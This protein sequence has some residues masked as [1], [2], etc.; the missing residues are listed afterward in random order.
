MNA[1][2]I[3]TAHLSTFLI[4]IILISSTIFSTAFIECI[5]E[6][7]LFPSCIPCTELQW[8]I[9]IVSLL[10]GAVLGSVMFRNTKPV[11]QLRIADEFIILG[12]IGLLSSFSYPLIVGSRFCMGLGLGLVSTSVLMYFKQT[13]HNKFYL[14]IIS[15][16]YLIGQL[17]S[18]LKWK[19][20]ISII[21]LYTI[22]HRIMLQYISDPISDKDAITPSHPIFNITCFHIIQQFT[23]FLPLLIYQFDYKYCLFLSL[24][25]FVALFIKIR[26]KILLI[27]SLIITIL[28]LIVLSTNFP[29]GV[30]GFL[31]IIG[32]S[33]GIGSI[34]YFMLEKFS[35]EE[36]NKQKYI[37]SM[38][39]LSGLIIVYLFPICYAKA[40]N[41]MFLF[42]SGLISISSISM[43]LRSI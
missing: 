28:A 19:L 8:N 15:L 2:S 27:I 43:I 35:Y 33:L 16:G 37:M 31:F 21:L 24:T 20:G 39:W 9:I 32:Y 23:C 40:G 6:D 22:I 3:I 41:N 13:K 7:V 30:G 38:N 4:G 29:F 26:K 34:P 5:Y 18:L 1:F 17:L 25:S 10:G 11:V 12:L 14:F 42:M 36:T